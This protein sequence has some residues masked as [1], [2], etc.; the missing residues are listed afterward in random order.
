MR[1]KAAETQTMMAHELS[2][3]HILEVSKLIDD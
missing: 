1:R 3:A 2:R